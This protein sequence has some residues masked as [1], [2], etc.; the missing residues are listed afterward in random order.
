MIR[1]LLAL[2]RPL[3]SIAREFVRFNDNY[4]E[5]LL[6]REIT[7]RHM[8]RRKPIDSLSTLLGED[9]L[10]TNVMDEEVMAMEEALDAAGYEGERE[11]FRDARRRA[12]SPLAISEK[13][14]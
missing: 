3:R 11:E 12:I 9:E 10:E 2:L 7:P 1:L 6:A 5:D 14:R 8:K 4:E 13:R